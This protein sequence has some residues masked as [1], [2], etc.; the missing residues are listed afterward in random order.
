MEK[1]LADIL[2]SLTGANDAL[3][4]LLLFLSAFIENVFPPA[5]GDTVTA[6]G[7]FLVGTAGSIISLYIWPR[8]SEAYLDS[9]VSL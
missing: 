6:F 5:P 7:A 3:L 1:A 4:Y 2:S 8:P 9:S